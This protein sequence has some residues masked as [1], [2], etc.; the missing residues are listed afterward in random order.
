MSTETVE[1]TSTKIQL[2]PVKMWKVVFL[3]DDYTPMDFVVAVLM[4]FYKKTEEEAE[5]IAGA[6]HNQGRGVAGIF[7]QEIAEQKAHDT[8]KVS[9]HNGHPLMAAAEEL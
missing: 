3:N 6:I 1:K 5:Q 7:T 9:R 8:I 4:R 2:K